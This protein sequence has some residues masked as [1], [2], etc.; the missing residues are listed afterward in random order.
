MTQ[1]VDLNL[2]INILTD[3]SIE[4]ISTMKNLIGLNLCLNRLENINKLGKLTNLKLLDLNQNMIKALDGIQQL[5]Q[6]EQFDISYNKLT[7]ITELENLTNI[8]T[9]NISNNQIFSIQSISKLINL[10]YLNISHNTIFSIEICKVFK[11]LIDLRTNNNKIQDLWTLMN[12]QN[13]KQFWYNEQ[14]QMDNQDYEKMEL[15]T[16]QLSNF[17]IGQKYKMNNEKMLLKY[18]DHVMN[19]YLLIENDDE[20]MNLLFADVNKVK[21]IKIEN[22]KNLVFDMSPSQVQVLSV[23]NSK[24]THITHLN[25]IEQ[26]TDLDLSNNSIRDISELEMLINLIRL[27]LSSNDIYRIDSLKDLMKLQYLNISNNKILVCEPLKD[28]NIT[29]LVIN[30]NLLNDLDFIMNMKY[31]K[32]QLNSFT[33]YFEPQLIDFQNYLGDNFGS[34]KTAQKMM[35]SLHDQRTQTLR[36]IN[37]SQIFT[38]YQ[39]KVIDNKLIIENELK[40]TSIEFSDKLNIRELIINKCDNLLFERVPKLVTNL[41]VNNSFIYHLSGIEQ[42]TQLTSLNVNSNKLLIIEQISQLTDLK[43]FSADNNYIQDYQCVTQLP[44]FNAEFIHIQNRPTNIDYQNYIN[45][46]GLNISVSELIVDLSEQKDITEY[47]IYD[48]TLLVKFKD[49]VKNSELT[50]HCD[51][52]IKDIKF[53]DQLPV[54]SIILLN[55]V[56]IQ[57][58]RTPCQITHLSI[59]NCNLTNMTGIEQMNQLR[60]LNL[61]NNLISNLSGIQQLQQLSSLNLNG[62]KLFNFNEIS[63]LKQLTDLSLSNNDI[64]DLNGIEQMIQLQNLNLSN[65][66]INSVSGIEKLEQLRSL[67]LNNNRIF[68]I[69]PVQNLINLSN[70]SADYNFITDF[71]TLTS[72]PNFSDSFIYLQNTPSDVDLEHYLRSTSPSSEF[73]EQLLHFNHSILKNS[74]LNTQLIQSAYNSYLQKMTTKYRSKIIHRWEGTCLEIRNDPELRDVF[75]IH[76]FQLTYY[77]FVEGCFNV[78]L[79]QPLNV[80]DLTV[81]RCGLRDI[82]GIEK[83]QIKNLDLQ[84]N[85]IADIQCLREMKDMRLNL[86][87]NQIHDFTALEEHTYMNGKDCNGLMYRLGQQKI[88]IYENEELNTQTNRDLSKDV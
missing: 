20:V 7:Q 25:Q 52:Q 19:D 10:I 41:T 13:F 35:N 87:Y 31:F 70:F 40:L 36:I 55:C 65:N 28:L 34:V 12:H 4:I 15:T 26:L 27:N 62:N 57:F 14:N 83:I 22:C 72:L 8:N 63:Q 37:N 84:H 42:M 50:I 56:N 44:N 67:N 82:K 80:T 2:G 47:L 77:L 81:R 59:E 88:K 6:L 5:K 1:L 60:V 18:K 79:K 30:N 48:N 68:F 69:Q 71:S 86:E 78:S 53:V 17:K 9:L 58:K 61:T 33:S 46:N 66:Y 74:D 16:R 32:F 39:S 38:R 76:S 29:E 75:F 85:Y 64:N 51:E 23:R 73:T 54:T 49:S 43:Y 45:Q 3:D 21:K 11:K 24:L